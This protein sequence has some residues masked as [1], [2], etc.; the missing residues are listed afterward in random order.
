MSEHLNPRKS[1]I[2]A[3]P[4]PDKSEQGQWYFQRYV[5]ILPKA[6]EI[7]FFNRSWYNRAVVEPVNKFCT[8]EQYERFMREVNLFEDMLSNDGIQII[9]FYYSITREEQAKRFQLIRNNPLKKWK[10][11]PVDIKAQELWDDYTVYKER[12]LR[13]SNSKKNPWLV[14]NA[15]R[16]TEARIDSLEYVL[17]K[18]PYK[19]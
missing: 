4:K 3:L 17:S 18:V 6:G 11:S 10:L 1:R 15:N 5:K 13:E 19:G 16:K 8:E 12:M 9:K 14:I 2:V 7:V